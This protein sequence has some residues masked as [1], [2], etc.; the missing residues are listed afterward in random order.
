MIDLH[1]ELDDGVLVLKPSGRID[2]ANAREYEHTLMDRIAKGHSKILMN[3][4]SIEYIS[5]AGLRVLLMTSRRASEKAGKLV[6]CAVRE[7]V[8]DVFKHSGFAE[9]IPIHGDLAAARQ[10]F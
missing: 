2:G 10:A 6:L 4:E 1:D 9:I 7:P 3:C 8:H 5:S